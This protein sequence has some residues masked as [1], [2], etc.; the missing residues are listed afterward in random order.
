MSWSVDI[1]LAPYPFSRWGH[2]RPNSDFDSCR[3]S[4]NSEEFYCI[5][6]IMQA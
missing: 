3:P 5:V 1:F 2:E 4:A 6:P